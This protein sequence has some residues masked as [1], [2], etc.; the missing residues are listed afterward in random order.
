[1]IL[2]GNLE[3]SFKKINFFG[4]NPK[5]VKLIYLE[6]EENKNKKTL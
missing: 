1:L 6:L 4:K 5:K 2:E 3:L